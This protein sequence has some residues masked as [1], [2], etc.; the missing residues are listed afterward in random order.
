MNTGAKPTL[1]GGRLELPNELLL[2]PP[3]SPPPQPHPASL[4]SV[5]WIQHLRSV[6]F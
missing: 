1:S 3:Y 2:L 6:F 5:A 4:Y